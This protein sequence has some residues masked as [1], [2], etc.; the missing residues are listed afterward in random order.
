M[1]YILAA[2]PLVFH[3]YSDTGESHLEA[4]MVD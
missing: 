1:F 3:G 2:S 4:L